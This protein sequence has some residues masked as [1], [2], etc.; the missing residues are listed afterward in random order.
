MHLDQCNGF[1]RVLQPP[2]QPGTTKLDVFCATLGKLLDPA[3]QSPAGRGRTPEIN[4]R[5]DNYYGKLTI[6]TQNVMQTDVHTWVAQGLIKHR[7]LY[8][9]RF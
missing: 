3:T 7:K 4:T 6:L 2:W 1:V 5:N 8:E 9:A